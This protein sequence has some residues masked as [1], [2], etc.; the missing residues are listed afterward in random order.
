MAWLKRAH[1]NAQANVKCLFPLVLLQTAVAWNT[2]KS[3]YTSQF[4]SLTCNALMN[5]TIHQAANANHLR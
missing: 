3:K 1:F 5:C 4:L 2:S